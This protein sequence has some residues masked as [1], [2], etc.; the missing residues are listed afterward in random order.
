MQRKRR[1]VFLH[2]IK[3]GGFIKISTGQVQVTAVTDNPLEHI[4][5]EILPGNRQRQ[6]RAAHLNPTGMDRQDDGRI[7]LK[8]GSN[9]EI[10]I[11]PV[12]ALYVAKISEVIGQGT[13][14]DLFGWMGAEY[15]GGQLRI[16]F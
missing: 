12:A 9:P 6:F 7:G 11:S 14:A 8:T 15:F 10:S 4:Q 3:S 2:Q 16:C 1:T 13:P 5:R